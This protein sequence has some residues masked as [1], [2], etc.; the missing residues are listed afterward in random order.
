MK[1]ICDQCG[2]KYSVDDSKVQNKSFK[3]TCKKCGNKIVIHPNE[4]I[5]KISDEDKTVA[6]GSPFSDTDWGQTGGDEME[7]DDQAT[8][9]FS[10]NDVNNPEEQKSSTSAPI[11][12]GADWY[13]H[14]NGE[15]KGPLKLQELQK[16][17]QTQKLSEYTNAWRTGMADWIYIKDIPELS[18]FIVTS[19]KNTENPFGGV[20]GGDKATAFGKMSL[21]NDTDA[22][23]LFKNA[24]NNETIP[25]MSGNSGSLF[26]KNSSMGS[27]APFQTDSTLSSFGNK[28]GGSGIDLK[29]L[30]NSESIDDDDDADAS[31]KS[32]VIDFRDIAGNN[33]KRV[34]VQHASFNTGGGESKGSKKGLMI[35]LVIMVIVAIAAVGFV[36]KTMM[37]KSEAFKIAIGSDPI[38]ATV[39]INGEQK[40]FTPATLDLEKGNYSIKLSKDGFE[41]KNEFLTINSATTQM[42]KMEE[43]FF[44]IELKSEPSGTVFINGEN[45]GDTPIS[46]K[47][48]KGE[49]NLKISKEGF[50]DID[51]KLDVATNDSKSFTL[52]KQ[53]TKVA[54]NKVVDDS[55][56][57]KTTKTTKVDAKINKSTKIETKKE[58]TENVAVKD[59][60]KEDLDDILGSKKVTPKKEENLPEKLTKDQVLNVIKSVSPAVSDCGQKAGI[61][62][63]VK[64]KFQVNGSG[65]VSNIEVDPAAGK[66]ANCITSKVR[67]MRFSKFSGAAFPVTFPFKI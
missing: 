53:E 48:K 55:K 11:T 28:N 66:A 46:L 17:I 39:F 40:G 10:Y 12:S 45:K 50:D 36:I 7:F 29:S 44:S 20:D 49:Y 52:E 54:S 14:V 56:T 35:A 9:I 1:I 24:P 62:G 64:V 47:L 63:T 5:S 32:K 33:A 21:L 57:T 60:K 27:D 38:G 13:I 3:I 25:R 61:S 67:G 41:E 15:Q 59:T 42:Y 4:D 16:F 43:K 19:P 31:S 58:T 65:A 6:D 8:K 30:I 26:N 34:V 18:T 2:A 37:G 23:S 22:E 51:G